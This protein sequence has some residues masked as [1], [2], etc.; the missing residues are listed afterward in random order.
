[1][2]AAMFVIEIIERA[3]ANHVPEEERPVRIGEM[4][5][6]VELQIEPERSSQI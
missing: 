1:M 3:H 4:Q 5:S 6:A 2:S